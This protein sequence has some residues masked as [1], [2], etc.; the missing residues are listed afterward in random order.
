MT[1]QVPSNPKHYDSMKKH[2]YEWLGWPDNKAPLHIVW[3]LAPPSR[4][5]CQG[6]ALVPG[7]H[8]SAPD[9]CDLPTRGT[10]LLPSCTQC[11]ACSG[12]G[13]HLEQ[14]ETKH[15]TCKDAFFNQPCEFVIHKYHF[16]LGKKITNFL[17]A[18]ACP[19]RHRICFSEGEILAISLEPCKR[20][21]YRSG[22]AGMRAMPVPAGIWHFWGWEWAGR[23][24]FIF[25]IWNLC[26]SSQGTNV[27][28]K[29]PDSTAPTQAA[30][31][32][33]QAHCPAPLLSAMCWQQL[34]FCFAGWSL[35][36]HS[37]WAHSVAVC[38]SPTAP[39]PGPSTAIVSGKA[40]SL[41]KQKSPELGKS[42]WHQPHSKGSWT[43]NF[44]PA[45]LFMT[46]STLLT[47]CQISTETKSILTPM[48]T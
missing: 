46:C 31:T 8:D 43:W 7:S 19:Q 37:G 16:I 14:R 10:D 3:Y 4:Q 36:L 25:P 44:S 27:T 24:A 32:P 12:C 21:P 30:P 39:S 17:E 40:V 20:K 1:F 38:L 11:L 42:F 35:H 28:A 45:M 33:A 22:W 15:S 29:L 2:V 47:S 41:S 9:L 18:I 6:L 5:L 26:S 48:C 23:P 34:Y 13:P